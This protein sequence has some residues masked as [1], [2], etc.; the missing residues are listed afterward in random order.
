MDETPVIVFKGAFF[1]VTYI[2]MLKAIP[3][4]ILKSDYTPTHNR[5]KYKTYLHFFL[6]AVCISYTFLIYKRE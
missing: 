6:D 5:D 1:F 4:S 2:L 3:S